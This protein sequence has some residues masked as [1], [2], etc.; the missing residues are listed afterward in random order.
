MSLGNVGHHVSVFN[1]QDENGAEGT[2][3]HIVNSCLAF[4]HSHLASRD[5]YF[6]REKVCNIFGLEQIKAARKVLF[7]T[8]DPEDKYS[9]QGPKS[10]KATDKD[11]LHDAFEGI[12]NRICKLDAGNS[13]AVF[14]I[15]SDE[16][17]DFMSLFNEVSHST[18][19]DRFKK[20][21]EKSKRLEDKMEEIHTT[22]KSF[23]KISTSNN[24]PVFP[25]CQ[26]AIHPSTRNRLVSS[27]SKR[28]AT[29]LS[30]DDSIM[31]SDLISDDEEGFS[32]PRAQRKKAR[33]GSGS[34]SPKKKVTTQPKSDGNFKNDKPSYS[35]VATRKSLPPATKGTVKSTA[36]FRC[37]VPDVFLFN[38]H[39]KCSVE[40]VNE[41]YR[42]CDIKVRKVE[43]KSHELSARSSFKVSP[44]S[45]GDYEKIL[46]AEFLPEEV[47]ARK[48][49]F[50]KG[51]INTDRKEVFK[52]SNGLSPA[53]NTLL[54]E[55]DAISGNNIAA[56]ESMDTR[57]NLE[58]TQPN[59][60]NG[61]K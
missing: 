7:T 57:S 46:S 20:M 40:D 41:Y 21:E 8:Y 55:L 19:E 50:R 31:P 6:I 36:V 17:L 54:A 30:E 58:E 37:A 1:I 12:Y 22:F 42:N 16:L 59:I 44:E 60:N 23:I 10:K 53:T 5:K 47:C 15:P 28:S 43:K 24:Q 14:S 9:Y 25:P 49:I 61:S 4:I 34:K 35:Q 45:M 32:F 56:E 33:R 13:V 2:P 38:C 18:C 52:S 11:K 48:Y 29:E 51:K 39:V 26:P 3:P 27:A